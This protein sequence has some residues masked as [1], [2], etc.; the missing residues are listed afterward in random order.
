MKETRKLIDKICLGVCDGEEGRCQR[1]PRLA[2][3][4]DRF[5]DFKVAY[6]LGRKDEAERGSK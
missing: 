5:Q 4:C 3:G 6:L 1:Y 2:G